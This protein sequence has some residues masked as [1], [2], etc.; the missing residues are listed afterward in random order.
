MARTKTKRRKTG[1]GERQLAW[2]GVYS[3]GKRRRDY[4][5][6]A[7]A[8]IVVAAGAALF[9][10]RAA[11]D[12]RAFLDLA[13]QG[14]PAL[15]R[16]QSFRSEGRVHLNPNQPVEYPGR[17]PTSGDHYL[18]RAEPGFYDQP[19]PP[20]HLVHAAEHG[21]IVIYYDE[22]GDEVI[23]TLRGWTRLYG[24]RW[25]GLVATHMPGLGATVVLT[26]WTKRMTLQSFDAAAA[27]AFIDAY[28]GRGP[29][30]SVR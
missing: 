18:I 12:E 9:W 17:F 7:A 20:A 25:D 16:V 14:R 24:G 10:W 8:A 6:V 27:A 21:N 29:E 4:V 19:Q 22:P 30:N 11:G 23:A 3:Q 5:I 26:A 13:A 2:G 28:R 1:A 15:V